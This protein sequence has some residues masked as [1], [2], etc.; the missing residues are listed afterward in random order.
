[1][2]LEIRIAFCKIAIKQASKL[3]IEHNADIHFRNWPS[4]MEIFG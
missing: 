4:V 1:M 2:K 3:R